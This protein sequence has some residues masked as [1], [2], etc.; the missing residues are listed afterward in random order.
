MKQRSIFRASFEES[1][2]LEDDILLQFQ[3]KDIYSKLD[4]AFR[5]GR[6]TFIFKLQSIILSILFPIGLNFILYVVSL[7]L[8]DTEL[9]KLTV[10][11]S[12]FPL[13]TAQVYLVCLLTWLVLV[14]IGKFFRQNFILPYRYRFHI[15]TFLIWFVLEFNLLAID[16]SLLTLSLYGILA[17]F[18][19]I[20][21]LT[22]LMIRTQVKRLR[23]LFYHASSVPSLSDKI[24]RGLAVYGAG[25]LGLGTLINLMMKGLSVEFSTTVEGLGLLLTWVLLDIGAVAMLVFMEFPYFLEGYYKLKYP[26]EYRE[27]EGQAREDWYGKNI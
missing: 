15:D 2:N 25:L 12:P 6:P 27:W 3:K 24:A 7:M 11:L 16:I 19:C 14:L 22:Y 13:L 8:H 23:H 18:V 1:L 17:I 9:Y 4:K 5:R 10:P 26:E 21:A 20:G